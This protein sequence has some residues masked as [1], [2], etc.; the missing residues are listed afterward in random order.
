M[1]AVL[2]PN[3]ATTATV[4]ENGITAFQLVLAP[5]GPVLMMAVQLAP[6]SVERKISWFRTA[7]QSVEVRHCTAPN[8]PPPLNTC[9]QFTPSSVER[10]IFPT[11]VFL[12]LPA[13]RSPVPRSRRRPGSWP[14]WHYSRLR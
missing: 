10:R 2:P 7:R 9:V 5:A 3:G 11:L 13:R 4:G 8:G 6:A 14:P 12:A 1:G